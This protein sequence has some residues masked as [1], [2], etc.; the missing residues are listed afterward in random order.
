MRPFPLIV[1]LA[2]VAAMLVDNADAIKCYVE[3]PQ[4]SPG[5][6]DKVDCPKTMWINPTTKCMIYKDEYG[7]WRDCAPDGIYEANKN[8]PNFHACSSDYCNGGDP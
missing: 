8:D 5:K 7:I 3:D 1:G 4:I 2:F 6:K